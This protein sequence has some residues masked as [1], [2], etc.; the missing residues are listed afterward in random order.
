[1]NL[2][3]FAEKPVAALCETVESKT[4]KFE[5]RG[6][7]PDFKQMS[8]KIGLQWLRDSL[9][10]LSSKKLTMTSKFH[11]RVYYTHHYVNSKT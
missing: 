5:L 2:V 8:S 6:F 3:T 9:S 4:K 1:V 11:S 10:A 7:L